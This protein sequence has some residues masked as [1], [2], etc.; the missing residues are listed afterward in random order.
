MCR[1]FKITELKTAG[2]LR[3]EN[4]H[5][6]PVTSLS[7]TKGKKAQNHVEMAYSDLHCLGW[8]TTGSLGTRHGGVG[9]APGPHST[10]HCQLVVP[11]G[12]ESHL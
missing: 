3:A 11:P 8:E 10:C 9:C 12:R 7:R 2:I 5:R 6:L 1:G 4:P